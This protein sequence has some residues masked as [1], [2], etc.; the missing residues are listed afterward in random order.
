MTTCQFCGRSNDT[1]ET[2]CTG[3][4]LCEECSE[5]FE[6]ASIANDIPDF[7]ERAMNLLKIIHNDGG[8]APAVV[9]ALAHN[10]YIPA[11]KFPE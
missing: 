9:L 1:V 3:D 8:D 4:V 2:S 10:N 5:L 7:E 6:L 11:L